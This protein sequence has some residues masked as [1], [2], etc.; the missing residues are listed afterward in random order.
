MHINKNYIWLIC[1]SDIP[2]K[3]I[4]SLI[5]NIYQ[6]DIWHKMQGG[7]TEKL[8]KYMLLVA[9]FFFID[10]SLIKAILLSWINN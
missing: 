9:I 7:W 3:F 4:A 5:L 2:L 6:L 1:N 10:G 8:G